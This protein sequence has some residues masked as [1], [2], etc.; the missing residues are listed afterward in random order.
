MLRQSAVWACCLEQP[1]LPRFSPFVQMKAGHEKPPILVAHGL[2]GSARF[3]ELAKQ[4]RTG[5]AICGNQAMGIDGPRGDRHAHGPQLPDW[6]T[7][8]DCAPR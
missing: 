6:Q 2:E 3:F 7:A 4:I 1:T 8:L 5:H